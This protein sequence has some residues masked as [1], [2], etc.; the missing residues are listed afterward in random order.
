YWDFKLTSDLVELRNIVTVAKLVIQSAL[1]RK[2]SRGLHYNIGYPERDD[3]RFLSPTL[4]KKR[5]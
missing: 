1:L 4:L 3:K 5:F 2:E